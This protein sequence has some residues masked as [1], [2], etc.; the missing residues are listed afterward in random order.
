MS[1]NFEDLDVL[2]PSAGGEALRGTLTAD[3]GVPSGRGLIDSLS[4]PKS[5]FGTL[6]IF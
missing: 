3:A 1:W 5:F 6:Y 4:V 2:F